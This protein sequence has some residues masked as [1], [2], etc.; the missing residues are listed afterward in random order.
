MSGAA[1]GTRIPRSAVEQTVKDYIDNIPDFPIEGI[2]Y[3]DI[4]PLLADT[5]AFES[6][7]IPES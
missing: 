5:V 7:V 1:G 2:Q 3:K 6:K 4:Q